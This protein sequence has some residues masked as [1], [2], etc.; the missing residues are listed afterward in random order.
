[1]NVKNLSKY[2]HLHFILDTA[3]HSSVTEANLILHLEFNEFSQ[4]HDIKL[5]NLKDALLGFPTDSGSQTCK[6]M[7]PN[8]G[9]TADVNFKYA[10]RFTSVNTLRQYIGRK[11]CFAKLG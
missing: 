7:M 11:T 4:Q 6:L 8:F 5:C 9:E 2:H 1:M 10:L 3:P